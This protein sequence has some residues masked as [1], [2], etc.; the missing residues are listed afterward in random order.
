MIQ[1]H[2]MKM[3]A[4]VIYYKWKVSNFL[5]LTTKVNEIFTEYVFINTIRT[6]CEM[7][8][9]HALDTYIKPK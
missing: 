3:F 7:I 8:Q 6:A 4:A 1:N 2:S 5:N 9:P